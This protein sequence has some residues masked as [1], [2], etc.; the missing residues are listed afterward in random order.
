MSWMS[1]LRILKWRFFL[2]HVDRFLHKKKGYMDFSVNEKDEVVT[3]KL[4]SSFDVSHYEKFKVICSEN[5]TDTNRFEVDF[6]NT[7]YLDSSALG[8]LLLLRDQ[9]HGEKDRVTLINVKDAALKILTIAQFQQL[10][11]IEEA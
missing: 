3:I 2:Y 5:V 1:E 4:D 10:F 9:T 6:A 11:N 8:M 7:Q